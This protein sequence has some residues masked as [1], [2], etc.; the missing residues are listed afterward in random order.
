MLDSFDQNN[1]RAKKSSEE[2]DNGVYPVA[3]RTS[4]DTGGGFPVSGG[5]D[6]VSAIPKTPETLFVYWE[7]Q[8][9]RSRNM[10]E[11]M[12]PHA[13]WVLRLIDLGS[14]KMEPSVE[15]DIPVDVEAGDYYL[16]VSPGG[17]YRVELG[18]KA[19]R[20]FRAVCHTRDRFMPVAGHVPETGASGQGGL[21][22]KAGENSVVGKSV[23]EASGGKK[24][25]AGLVWDPSL[26]GMSS[27]SR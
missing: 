13:K 3:G 11:K 7:L 12:G 17:H 1:G 25:P 23:S 6:S 21:G 2:H 4:D 14:G 19:G 10:A 27:S 16:H 8:G 22:K 24:L 15:A 9:E 5:C 20:V 18:L 26:T